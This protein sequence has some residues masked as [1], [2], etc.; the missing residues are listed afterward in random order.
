MKNVEY[1]WMELDYNS[2]H[3]TGAEKVWSV[4]EPV[5]SSFTMWV[6]VDERPI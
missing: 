2:G 3:P 4:E 1:L 5:T 6:A